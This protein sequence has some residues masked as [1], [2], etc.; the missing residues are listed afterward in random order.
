MQTPQN[1]AKVALV[2]QS[3]PRGLFGTA[4]PKSRLHTS[5]LCDVTHGRHLARLG[6]TLLQNILRVTKAPKSV[7][8][9]CCV[10]TSHDI[11][12]D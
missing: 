3:K 2:A 1:W 8:T 5:Y 10:I 7:V 9:N 4:Q 6:R 12:T 11:N